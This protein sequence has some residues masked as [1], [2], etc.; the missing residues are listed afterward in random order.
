VTIHLVKTEPTVTTEQLQ[1]LI[2]RDIL[3][4]KATYV[5]GTSNR[6]H[7]V[8]LSAEAMNGK[9]LNPAISLL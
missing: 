1:S 8:K 2:F 9:I 6:V 7:N 4:E 3:A 5:S